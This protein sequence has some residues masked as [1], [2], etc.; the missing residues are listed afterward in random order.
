MQ[1]MDHVLLREVTLLFPLIPSILFILSTGVVIV[2]LHS[3]PRVRPFF[4]LPSTALTIGSILCVPQ[5]TD[6]WIPHAFTFCQGLTSFYQLLWV[7]LLLCSETSEKVDTIRISDA[8]SGRTYRPLSF[9]TMATA[10]RQWNNPRQLSLKE[11]DFRT[12]GITL[13]AA[14]QFT[15]RRGLKVA[16]F[17]LINILVVQ[18][19]FD[20]IMSRAMLVDFAEESEPLIRRLMFLDPTVTLDSEQFSVR[21]LISFHWIW[22]DFLTLESCHAVLAV[23]FVVILQFDSIDEWPALYG[24]LLDAWSVKRFWGRYWHRI[25]TTTYS[26]YAR[27][28]SRRLC[29]SAPDT[30]T[31]KL[32]VAFFIFS[33][34][35]LGHSLVNWRDGEVALE[36]DPLF[37]IANFVV[38]TIELS[39]SK[40]TKASMRRS[41][42]ELV[43]RIWRTSGIGY[44]WVSF[45]FLCIVPRWE[46]PRIYDGWLRAEAEVF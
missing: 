4:V 18:P 24:N 10:Y 17:H 3:Q 27:V 26:R 12:T 5:G 42:Y 14:V 36:R 37:F 32:L 31:E 46:F 41:H 11:R 22:H 1:T 25:M 39:I 13:G 23:I 6:C 35:G 9:C 30:A 2:A 15:I 20:N 45:W 28:F 29:K 40:V 21:V 33:I 16:L 7:P 8:P 44:I 34:S 19:V 38:I 43:E